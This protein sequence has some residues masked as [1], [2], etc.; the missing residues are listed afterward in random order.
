MSS[1]STV[2]RRVW[3]A[4]GSGA[5]RLFRINSGMAWISGMGPKGVRHM[6]DGSVLIKAARPV[7][8]GF[9]LT[10]GKALSGVS[11]LCGW[12]TVRITPEM[13]GRDVAVFT[14]VETKRSKG[15]RASELQKNFIDQIEQA[16]GIA[17]VAAS[18][19][20]AKKIIQQFYLNNQQELL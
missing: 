20:D 2:M 16:G 17:G 14:A 4:L 9:G 7:A 8:M 15:G 6:Q 11:D 3:L 1:E 19:A 18:E 12:T 13:V 5:T 10:N